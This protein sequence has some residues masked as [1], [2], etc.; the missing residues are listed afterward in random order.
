M[1]HFLLAIAAIFFG[2]S[3]VVAQDLEKNWQFDGIENENGNTLIEVICN[4]GIVC[5][6]NC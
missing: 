1:K 2:I 3:T 5:P 6:I 4:L